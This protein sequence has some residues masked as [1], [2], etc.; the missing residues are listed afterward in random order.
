[1]LNLIVSPGKAAKRN[2]KNKCVFT[3]M[4]KIDQLKPDK[5]VKRKVR[6][7]EGCWILLTS[8][9]LLLK[10]QQ[11]QRATRPKKRRKINKQKEN[12]TK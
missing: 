4:F 6:N 3:L 5:F 12:K 8:N 1:M 2:L 7:K 10:G 11:N 9:R